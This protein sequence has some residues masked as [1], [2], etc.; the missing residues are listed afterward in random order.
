LTC[1]QSVRV[2]GS[3]F[4]GRGECG[5]CPNDREEERGHTPAQAAF[6]KGIISARYLIPAN[7]VNHNK[8]QTGDDSW[9]ALRWNKAEATTVNEMN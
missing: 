7:A 5:V 6:I 3:E 4:K 1:R 8:R 2:I 9:Q